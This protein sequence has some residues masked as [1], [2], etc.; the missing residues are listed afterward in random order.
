MF[1]GIRKEGL[2][3]NLT[4]PLLPV[5]IQRHTAA[6]EVCVCVCVCVC[7]RP[8]PRRCSEITSCAGTVSA[9]AAFSCPREKIRKRILS[10][11]GQRFGVRRGT[12]T[13]FLS[14]M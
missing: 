1:L 6:W 2:G 5:K 10:S 11:R 7:V 8:R 9:A 12:N 4:S 14:S 13:Q 3:K